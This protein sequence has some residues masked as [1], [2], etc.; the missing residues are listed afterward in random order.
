MA[1][2]ASTTIGGEKPTHMP[3]FLLTSLSLLASH[4]ILLWKGEDMSHSWYDR[5]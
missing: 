2:R 5:V 3:P 1:Y 4:D